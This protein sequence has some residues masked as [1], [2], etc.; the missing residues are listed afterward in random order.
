RNC[1]DAKLELNVSGCAV[2]AQLSVESTRTFVQASFRLD[3]RNQN[4]GAPIYGRMRVR[5]GIIPKPGWAVYSG[6][7]YYPGQDTAH[8]MLGAARLLNSRGFIGGG[9]DFKSQ[10]LRFEGQHD[11]GPKS[12]VSADY[13]C[14]RSYNELSEVAL[15]WRVQQAYELQLGASFDGGLFAAV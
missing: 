2:R 11:L 6:L 4:T 12:Y 13:Y 5:A 14:N 15:H 1:P 3:L 8:P 10:S 9:F 7:D